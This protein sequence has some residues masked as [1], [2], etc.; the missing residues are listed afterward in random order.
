MTSRLLAACLLFA[1]CAP[2]DTPHDAPPPPNVILILADDMGFADLGCFGATVIRTPH[3]D[4]LAEGGLRLTQFYNAGRCCPSRAS[5]LTGRTPHRAGMA[6][7]TDYTLP[8]NPAYQGYLRADAPTLAEVLRGAGYRTYHVGKWHVGGGAGQLPLD[9][10]FDRAFT[11]VGGAGSYYD[12]RPYRSDAWRYG[13]N[14]IR[15]RDEGV[16]VSPAD[17]LHYLTDLLTDRAV[18]YIRGAD[19]GVPFFLY[20]AYTAPHWPLHAPPEDVARYEG[21]FRVGWDSLRTARFARQRALGLWDQGAA[22]SPRDERVAAWA[23]V[24]DSLRDVY[25]RKMAVYAAMV[26]RMDQQIGRLLDTL[27][28]TGRADNTVV[29]FLSDNGGAKTDRIPFL[30]NRFDPAAPVGSPR[31]FEGYGARW[32]N[33]SDVPFRR[34]KADMHEGG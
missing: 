32:A 18:E 8:D 25:A 13:S 33:V 17:T 28:A 34:F 10:G 21:R 1:A 6:T 4:R 7:M 12:F 24:D 29:V 14:E 15:V 19:A 30:H 5:L 2:S 22:L 26:D 9:R 31:S 3:L 27:D 16:P 23:E 20:L 11:F